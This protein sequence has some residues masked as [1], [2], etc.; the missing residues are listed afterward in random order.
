[1]RSAKVRS[2]K[3]FIRTAT[4]VDVGRI[5]DTFTVTPMNALPKPQGA[6]EPDIDREQTLKSPSAESL[7]RTI[8]QA[9]AAQD[10]T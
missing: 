7:G 10:P 8:V 3:A 6:F 2:L 1:M 4:L 5:G 9:F